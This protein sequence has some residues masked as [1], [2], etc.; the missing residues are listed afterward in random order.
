[1]QIDFTSLDMHEKFLARLTVRPTA[2]LQRKMPHVLTA[3]DSRPG[4]IERQSQTSALYFTCQPRMDDA[5]HD[6]HD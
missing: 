2:F 4:W 5:P 1:M 3:P 6:T